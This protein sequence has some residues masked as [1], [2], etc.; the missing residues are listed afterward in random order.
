MVD[1]AGAAASTR[2]M[3]VKKD[4]AIAFP[5]PGPINPC[6]WPADLFEDSS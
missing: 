2:S 5:K 4:R 1:D 3:D 6:Q